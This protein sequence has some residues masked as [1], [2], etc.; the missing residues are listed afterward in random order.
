MKPALTL[1][2]ALPKCEVCGHEMHA[3]LLKPWNNHQVCRPCIDELTAD[4]PE[5]GEKTNDR[6]AKTGFGRQGWQ[7]AA[8]R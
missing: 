1:V 3:K 4:Y 7:G 8:G 5:G 2:G 6:K